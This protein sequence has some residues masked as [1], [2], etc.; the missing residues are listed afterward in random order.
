M[1]KSEV[2][3][4]GKSIR[5]NIQNGHEILE[6]DILN[7]Q[8]YRTSFQK[9]LASV[10]NQIS[11]ISKK[12][13]S[14]SIVSFRIKRIESILS[15]I[16]REKTMALG[17][18]GDIAGC[19]VLLYSDDALL[20]LVKKF[21]SLFNVKYFNDYLITSKNDGYRGYHLYIESPINANKLIEIQLRTVSAHKW[22]SLVE[23]IDILYDVKIK[24][25]EKNRDFQ[26]FLLLMAKTDELTIQDKLKIVKID[27]KHKIYYK[28]NE[29]FIQNYIQVRKD[30][31]DLSRSTNNYFII[32]VDSY[33]KSSLVSFESY[34]LAETKYFEMFGKKNKSH[35]VLTH[36]EKPNYKRVCIAYASYM[37]V[38]H[39]Y[40]E[41][42][43]KFT[44]DIINDNKIAKT[45]SNL[46][47]YT[48][49]IKRNLTDQMDM[50]K[51]EI[52]EFNKY[53]GSDIN[54]DGLK[55]WLVE[56]QDKMKQSDKISRKYSDINKPKHRSFFKKIFG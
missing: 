26:E 52:S 39:D 23:I 49:Y 5:L 9:D 46:D 3:R 15:K 33:K 18:M 42:W 21:N 40:L 45:Q 34:S 16:R 53:S 2:N 27:E 13:R 51:S 35:F 20:G 28:L 43:S 10:F 50:I 19:R 37:L 6:K 30:W 31:I 41:D 29:V 14:D 24:E 36:I 17:N 12:E 47:F 56:L 22:A 25:G 54:N 4:I 44:L 11:A 48:E 55:E 32:E 7:L 8:E 38:N 1:T